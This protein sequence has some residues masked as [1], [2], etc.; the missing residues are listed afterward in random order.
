[1]TDN[2]NMIPTELI[3][4]LANVMNQNTESIIQQNLGVNELKK[5]NENIQQKI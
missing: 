4:K 5:E 2:L 3:S 1:M